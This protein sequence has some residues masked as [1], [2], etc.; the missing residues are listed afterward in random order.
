MSLLPYLYDVGRPFRMMERHMFNP[1]EFFSPFSMMPRDVFGMD[2]IYRPWPEMFRPMERLVQDMSRL[3]LNELAST[4]SGIRSDG[5][6]FQINVDVQHFAPEEI[7]V[8]V[9]DGHVLIQGKHEEKRDQ[10]GYVSRQF[11]RRYALPPNV[12]PDTVRSSL[13][14]DGVLTVSAPKALAMPSIGER[15]VPIIHT[16][17]VQ[18]QIN[19]G[20]D[21][22]AAAVE[23]Q[24]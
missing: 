22:D 4:P 17:P 14:S 10:H 2:Q 21:V 1:N 7:N 8:K 5:E 9:A 11:V 3:V 20:P 24:K 19:S 23:E 13:S 18:K 15:I 12:L 16:G 6:K